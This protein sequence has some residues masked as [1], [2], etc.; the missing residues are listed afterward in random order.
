MPECP[1]E[2]K[3]MNVRLKRIGS[4]PSVPTNPQLIKPISFG[5]YSEQKQESEFNDILIGDLTRPHSLSVLPVKNKEVVSISP[6]ML[7][8]LLD[9]ECPV[10]VQNTMI[11]DCRYPYE[12]DGGH[13]K[14]AINIYTKEKM[15]NI[16][17]HNSL[18]LL[19]NPKNNN[20]ALILILHCEYSQHRGP[21]MY[22]F[23]SKYIFPRFSY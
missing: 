15:E 21:S 22:V 14:N 1:C 4:V 13:I 16:L 18:N 17:F 3:E 5:E 7:S 2:R 9:G 11:I 23:V 19:Y 10:S 12:Y 8:K 6:Y 20:S